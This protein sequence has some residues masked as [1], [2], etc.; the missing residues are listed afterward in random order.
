MTGEKDLSLSELCMELVLES[1]VKT[2][3]QRNC[4]PLT[5]GQFSNIKEKAAGNRED[6]PK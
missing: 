5:P 2:E 6:I 1:N 4:V 3:L